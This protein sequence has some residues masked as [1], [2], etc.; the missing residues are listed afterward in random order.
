MK[1]FL[2]LFVSTCIILILFLIWLS[3]PALK[4][5]LQDDV[6]GWRGKPYAKA[7]FHVPILPRLHIQSFYVQNNNLGFRDDTILLRKT[8]RRILLL[9]DSMMWGLGVQNPEMASEI[10]QKKFLENKV[11]VVN[12]TMNA[13]STDQEYFVYE[14]I[15]EKYKPDHVILFFHPN[16]ISGNMACRIYGSRKSR[17]IES[18]P[19]LN[20]VSKNCPNIIASP[21]YPLHYLKHM[22]F[23]GFLRTYPPEYQS[24]IKTT[25]RIILRLYNDVKKS[26]ARFS[27]VYVPFF[28]QVYDKEWEHSLRGLNLKENEM[29][30]HKLQK[31]LQD[32]CEHH[33]IEF[34]DMTA[35]FQKHSRKDYDFFNRFHG[36]W[37][38]EGNMF[39]AKFIFENVVARH[40]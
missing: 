28:A 13:Y 19:A 1:T 18:H 17:F 7:W 27:F 4:L 37:T 24:G 26:G 12:M 20:L 21:E 39:A 16:D 6:L 31:L 38:K 35:Y 2:K 29:D 36:H 22:D 8:K 34:A 3:L 25:Q 30:R 14:H 11:E 23:V 15:G 9:G 40:F 33:H 32:F 5:F 10:L